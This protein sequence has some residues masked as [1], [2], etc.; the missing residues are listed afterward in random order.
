VVVAAQ[1]PTA[2]R[3]RHGDGHAG[4]T[5]RVARAVAQLHDRLLGKGHPALRRRRRLSRE[6]ELRGRAR[7]ERDGAEVAGMT[8]VAPKLSV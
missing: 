8:P 5:H 6:C 1:A 4:L 7:A 3:D 2:R